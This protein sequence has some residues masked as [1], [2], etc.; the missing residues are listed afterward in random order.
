M[1]PL[2]KTVVPYE[3]NN[4]PNR[5]VLLFS[6]VEREK[7]DSLIC[8]VRHCSYSE[9][10]QPIMLNKISEPVRFQWKI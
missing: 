1:K 4:S 10:R 6:G 2:D 3:V 8:W 7:N 9:A 5:I